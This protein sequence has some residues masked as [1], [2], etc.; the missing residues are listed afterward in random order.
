[1][2]EILGPDGEPIKIE[3]KSDPPEIKWRCY[4][5]S[6]SPIYHVPDPDTITDVGQIF[7]RK[8]WVTEKEGLREG[9]LVVVETL[10][11]PT[12]AT[13]TGDN[14][15]WHATSGGSLSHVLVWRDDYQWGDEKV[16]CWTCIGSANLK[17]LKKLNLS[18]GGGDDG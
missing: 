5:E 10:F 13:I 2:S 7:D 4:E 14:H 12:E 15:G 18:K 1:M 6:G 17:A 8:H 9:M 3:S 16:A 11:G